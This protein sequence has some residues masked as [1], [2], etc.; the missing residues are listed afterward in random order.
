MTGGDQTSLFDAAEPRLAERTYVLEHGLPGAR[1]ARDEAMAQVDAHADEEWKE[2][3]RMC[4]RALAMR[5]RELIA[6]D[7]WLLMERPREPRVTGP[8][9]MR[10]R[11]EGWIEPTEIYRPNPNRK[12]H[13]APVRV[14]RSLIYVGDTTE[15]RKGA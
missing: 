7:L 3:A 14:W 4:L 1:R 11:K 15:G 6:D 12:S 8:L 13:A 5:R 2:R 9:M 10:A